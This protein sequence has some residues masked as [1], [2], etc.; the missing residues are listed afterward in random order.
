M[1]IKNM[2]LV[3]SLYLF[4]SRYGPPNF[5]EKFIEGFFPELIA[6]LESTYFSEH[7]SVIESYCLLFIL[8]L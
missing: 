1:L 4:F 3:F 2:L 7:K 8:E 6:S 5:V